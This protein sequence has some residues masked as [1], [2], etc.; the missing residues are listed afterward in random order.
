MSRAVHALQY[1]KKLRYYC[2]YS[3]IV[4]EQEHDKIW[5]N[6]ENFSFSNS[7]TSQM[8]DYSTTYVGRAISNI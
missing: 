4:K 7:S 3:R 6:E 2:N 5:G 8:P 1:T